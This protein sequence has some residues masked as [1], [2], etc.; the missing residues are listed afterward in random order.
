MSSNFKITFEDWLADKTFE[1]YHFNREIQDHRYQISVQRLILDE[2]YRDILIKREFIVDDFLKK[3]RNAQKTSFRKVRDS[4]AKY[5]LE[6]IES[7]K[8]NTEIL[9][10]K[11]NNLQKQLKEIDN[12]YFKIIENV[13]DDCDYSAFIWGG[14]HK[15]INSTNIDQHFRFA[16]LAK[17][18][19]QSYPIGIQLNC[20]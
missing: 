14:A 1:E 5:H 20:L 9:E 3:I 2:K 13:Y 15:F 18:E 6:R 16:K 17:D 10:I 19:I 4:L 7:K 8:T 12:K 11:L